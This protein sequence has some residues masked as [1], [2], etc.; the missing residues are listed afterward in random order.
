MKLEIEKITVDPRQR[1]ELGDITQLAGSLT[2]WGQLHPIIVDE[3]FHLITGFRRLTAAKSIGWTSIE[4]KTKAQLT[5]LEAQELELEEN[6]Q[7]KALTWQEEIAAKNKIHQLKVQ[8]LGQAQPG[9]GSSGW[10]IRDTAAM[11]GESAGTISQDV[12]LAQAISQ[13]PTLAEEPSKKSA[14]RKLRVMQERLV[15]NILGQRAAAATTT[16]QTVQLLNESAKDMLSGL[17]NE[18]VDLIVTDPPWGVDIDAM[19]N[20]WHDSRD[21]KEVFDDNAKKQDIQFGIWKGYFTVP[22]V[23]EVL[24]DIVRV[25]KPGAHLYLFCAIESLGEYARELASHG[26][27]VRSRPLVWVKNIPTATAV[28]WKF[29][30]KAEYILFAHKGVAGRVLNSPANDVLMYDVPEQRIHATEKPVDLL[31][32]L[33]ELSSS[34]GDLVVDPFAGSFS[35][36]RAAKLSDR[37]AIGAE[38]DADMCLKANALLGMVKP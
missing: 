18:S 36:G 23:D 37:R 12:S 9:P 22:A 24:P 13:F 26:M 4:A 11:L 6:V 5:P 32:Y 14:M 3:Q 17:A 30:G 25:L 2:R 15:L 16:Q 10:G 29:M 28:F 20:L 27:L 35:V 8:T 31:K 38:I 33:I 7:R 1:E 21:Q 19:A 34:K